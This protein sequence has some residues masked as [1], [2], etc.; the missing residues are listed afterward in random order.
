[1][2]VL[3]CASFTAAAGTAC[4]GAGGTTSSATAPVTSQEGGGTGTLRKPGFDVNG[5]RFDDVVLGSGG[6]F[7]GGRAGLS[8]E[9]TA[10]VAFPDGS[11]GRL[12]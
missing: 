12:F 1:M 8:A 9:S 5:D 11:G 3:S 7:L 6:I 10:L 2:L 4:G